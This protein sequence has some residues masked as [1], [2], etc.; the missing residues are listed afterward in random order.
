M[1]E[2]TLKIPDHKVDF[3]M[4]LIKQLGLEI[5]A[6]QQEISEFHKSIVRERIKKSKMNPER[7]LDWDQIQDN[8]I[9]E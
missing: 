5:T 1:K 2:I 9:L 7:L 4:E 3:V 6:E 8:F